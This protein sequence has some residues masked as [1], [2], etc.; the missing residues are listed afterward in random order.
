M[1]SKLY[2]KIEQSKFIRVFYNFVYPKIYH[3]MLKSGNLT[4]NK[5][6]QETKVI[7]SLTTIPSRINL[8][9]LTI[10]SLMNQT[11]KPDKIILWLDYNLKN[12]KLPLELTKLQELGLDIEYCNDFRSHKKYYGTLKKYIDDVII[13]TDDDVFYPRY[14]IRKLIKKHDKFPNEVICYRAHEI[15]YTAD[16]KV[17]PY[18]QWN[19]ESPNINNSTH[20][21]LPTGVS[22]VLYPPLSLY[23]DTLNENI[24]MKV[25]PYCDDIWLKIMEI[26]KGSK[27]RKVFSYS[28]HFPTISGSQKEG[29]IKKNVMKNNNDIEMNRLL[30]YYSDIDFRKLD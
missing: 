30:Q 4:L 14:F 16:G 15:K 11:M 23:R 18:S 19:H 2:S 13:T 22:G 25:S 8:V 21:L 3:V 5:E 7:V 1:I 27:V 29:L 20:F 6:K 24:F 10:S 12:Y 17:L 26:K 9:W 28:V